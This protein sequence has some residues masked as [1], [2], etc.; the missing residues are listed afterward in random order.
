MYIILWVFRNSLTGANYARGFLS[1]F[2]D[3]EFN[4]AIIDDY[5]LVDYINA[6]V[7]TKVVKIK[8]KNELKEELILEGF[9]MNIDYYLSK[10]TLPES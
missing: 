1:N 3:L 5:G 6:N 10:S 2:V 8:N 7:K 9:G 4:Y